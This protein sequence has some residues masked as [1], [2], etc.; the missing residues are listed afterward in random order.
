MTGQWLVALSSCGYFNQSPDYRNV[1]PEMQTPDK[2][3]ALA[4]PKRRI[5]ALPN[6]A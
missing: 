1:V 2:L 5:G 6:R 4:V 3:R